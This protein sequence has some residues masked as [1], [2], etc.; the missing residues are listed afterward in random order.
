MR[1]FAQDRVYFRQIFLIKARHALFSRPKMYHRHD[2]DKIKR[3]RYRRRDD[4]LPVRY[5]EELRHDKGRRSHDRRHYLSP[6]RGTGDD[7][8]G[9]L[10][11]ISRLF[12]ERDGKRSGGD[13]VSA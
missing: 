13:G 6:R 3:R 9:E 7:R 12:H 5:A 11:L 8:S 2:R 10:W 1:S 4:N